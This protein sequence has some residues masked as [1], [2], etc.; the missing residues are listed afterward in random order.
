MGTDNAIL[1]TDVIEQ[2]YGEYL[3]LVNNTVVTV[4]RTVFVKE[5]GFISFLH[6]ALVVLTQIEHY[7]WMGWVAPG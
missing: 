7:F 6:F 4:E 1:S 2:Q 5:K 3:C